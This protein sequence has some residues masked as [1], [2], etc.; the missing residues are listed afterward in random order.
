VAE[1]AAAT[2]AHEPLTEPGEASSRRPAA[3]EPSET[4]PAG[5]PTRLE[6]GIED[7]RPGVTD[8]EVEPLVSHTSTRGG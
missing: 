6:P 7:D 3:N 2:P 5:E 8:V 4:G 1:E